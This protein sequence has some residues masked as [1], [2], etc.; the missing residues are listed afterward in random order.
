M[1]W[2]EEHSLQDLLNS[3]NPS[4]NLLAVYLL[5][6]QAAGD[7]ISNLLLVDAALRLLNW[8]MDKWAQL[9]TDLPSSMLK[10]SSPLCHIHWLD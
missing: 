9:Y 7:A 5:C 6:N 3:S 8:D 1:T 4:S 10:A 2:C